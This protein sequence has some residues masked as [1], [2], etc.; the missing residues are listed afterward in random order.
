MLSFVSTASNLLLGVIVIFFCISLTPTIRLFLYRVH[1]LYKDTEQNT[2]YILSTSID[3]WENYGRNIRL[4]TSNETLLDSCVIS[5]KYNN[6]SIT[7][8]FMFKS[9]IC[10]LMFYTYFLFPASLTFSM[11][12][13]D[14]IRLITRSFISFQ[15]NN[16]IFGQQ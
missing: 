2:R 4:Y 1:I 16:L 12:K 8:S 15:Q 10:L 9:G 6:I 14:W 5:L 13:I 7:F 11:H 3:S